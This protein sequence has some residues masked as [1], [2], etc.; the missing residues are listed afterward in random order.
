MTLEKPTLPESPIDA[1]LD[2]G[3]RFQALYPEDMVTEYGET[4]IVYERARIVALLDA[5]GKQCVAQASA[6]TETGHVDTRTLNA[7]LDAVRLLQ[8]AISHG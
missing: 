3:G 7:Q 5:F 8:E 6:L 2:H 4:L 1:L